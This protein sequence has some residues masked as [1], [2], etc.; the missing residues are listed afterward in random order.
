M[1]GLGALTE[2]LGG[3]RPSGTFSQRFG[4]TTWLSEH[5]RI[6]EKKM[7]FEKKMRKRC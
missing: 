3:N 5:H 4:F 2:V 7:C 1:H 6:F